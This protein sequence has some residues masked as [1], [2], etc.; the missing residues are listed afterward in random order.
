MRDTIQSVNNSL[1]ASLVLKG[2]KY[3]GDIAKSHRVAQGFI[4]LK[5][6]MIFDLFEIVINYLYKD[7][8]KLED[9]FISGL[10]D[11]VRW[12]DILLG[13]FLF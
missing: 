7:Q 13:F 5:G 4:I 10:V 3:P 12:V 1:K 8:E 11:A 9:V 6:E 2:L